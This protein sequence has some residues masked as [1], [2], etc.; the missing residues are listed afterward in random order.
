LPA[1]CETRSS[2]LPC[3]T[4][5]WPTTALVPVLMLMGVVGKVIFGVILA[6]CIVVAA[7]AR[8]KQMNVRA[9]EFRRSG[10]ED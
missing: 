10:P 2:G 8:L 1:G 9:E 6:I 3:S 5:A 7:R 4:M